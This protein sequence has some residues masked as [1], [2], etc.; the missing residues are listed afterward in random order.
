MVKKIVR[1]TSALLLCVC[2]MLMSG[3]Q[4]HISVGTTDYLTG[5]SYPDAEKYQTGVFTYL[6]NE[7]KAV[8]VYWRSGEVEIIE[9][10]NAELSVNESGNELPEDTAMHYFLDN[11]VLRIRFC[12]SGAKI[13]VNALDKHLHL[14]IPKGINLSVHTTDALTKADT[15]NQKDVL[16]AALSGDMELGTVSSDTID[17]SSSSGSIR[18][19]NISAQSLK[20][21]ASSGS[22]DIGVISV[23]T[24]DCSTSSGDIT[25]DS[26]I[27]EAS[28]VTT[29]S[30]NVKLSLINVPSTE[31]HTSSGDVDLTL[32]KSGAEVLHATSSGKLL[33]D[34]TYGRKGDLYVF[35]EGV[36]NIT[37][38]TSSGNLKVQ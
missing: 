8:E 30:G 25:L 17:L 26:M 7:I 38:E 6:A 1:S 36:S 33:T 31:I 16:I 34:C 35:D 13:Q 32:A 5:E 27:S 11:G 4:I 29:S 21:S 19:D 22:V 18:A 14:E 37:V 9:S 3:C 10:D 24:L 20:C 2:V 28:A 23:E 15:L 12:E